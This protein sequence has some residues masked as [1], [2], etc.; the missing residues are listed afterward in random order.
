MAP[1]PVKSDSCAQRGRCRTPIA[2]ERAGQRGTPHG[3][4]IPTLLAKIPEEFIPLAAI[5][6]GAFVLVFLALFHGTGLHRIL[7]WQRRGERRLRSGRPRILAA[8]FLF[9]WAV[10]LML[11]L[12]IIEIMI[13]AFALNHMGLVKH[14]YDAIYFCA[15]GYTTLGMGKME[16]EEHWRVISPIIGISGLFTFAWTT[17][18]LVDVVASHRQVLNQMEEEREQQLRMRFTL[19]KEQWDAL[20]SEREAERADKENIRKAA[21]GYWLFRRFRVWHEER[22]I[23][24]E[25][26]QRYKTEMKDL[27]RQERLKEKEGQAKAAAGDSDEKPSN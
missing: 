20:K 9:G 23:V 8:L 2:C 13:W 15:N 27:L 4:N 6:I 26:R 25:L 12:H 19:R 7:V 18:A 14:A 16:L 17:S 1:A 10:F 24:A 3:A 5:G 21:T 22:E 11:D